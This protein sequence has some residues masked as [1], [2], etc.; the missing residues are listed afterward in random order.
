VAADISTWEKVTAIFTAVGGVGAMLGAGAA[1]LA[2]RASGQAAR[3][4]KDALA[5]S[6]KPQVQLFLS[7]YIGPGGRVEARAVVRGPLS[8]TGL[9]GV[10]PA[11]DVELQFNLASGADGSSNIPILEASAD[12]FAREPPYLNVVIAEPSDEWPPPE[13]EEVTVTV[14]YSD[15]R[16]VARYQQ[17]ISADLRPAADGTPGLVSFQNMTTSVETRIK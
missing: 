16:Q 10:L 12:R 2:A 7:Q 17:T 3:D 14:S 11:A 13:G 9:R 5:A 4:A 8:P 6:L 1:W 15:E